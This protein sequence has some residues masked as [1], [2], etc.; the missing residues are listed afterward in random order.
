MTPNAVVWSL[1]EIRQKTEAPTARAVAVRS[2]LSIHACASFYPDGFQSTG[3]VRL[4]ICWDIDYATEKAYHQLK[5]HTVSSQSICI[6]SFTTEDIPSLV[7]LF[8][9]SLPTPL[10]VVFKTSTESPK[11]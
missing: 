1:Q 3:C 10:Y 5:L 4:D 2:R 6:F 9:E 8:P 11:A 7:A